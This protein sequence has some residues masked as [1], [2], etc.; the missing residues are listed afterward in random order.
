[1]SQA[2][3]VSDQ[4]SMLVRTD[5]NG[6]CIMVRDGLEE[7]AASAL[8]AEM[9]AR[10]HKQSFSVLSYARGSR[11]RMVAAHRIQE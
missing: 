8:Q 5:D 11:A 9:T 10:G 1:M 4:V 6:V 3:G 7:S 2:Q